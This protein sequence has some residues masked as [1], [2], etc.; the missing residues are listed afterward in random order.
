MESGRDGQTEEGTD[1]LRERRFKGETVCT[2]NDQSLI[3]NELQKGSLLR[4]LLPS[5]GERETVEIQRTQGNPGN[6][7]Y[8]KI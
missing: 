2:G 4:T 7:N 3:A 1:G 6:A 8:D 5:K